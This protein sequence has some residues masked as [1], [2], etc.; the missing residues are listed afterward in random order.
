MKRLLALLGLLLLAA[1]ADAQLF[2]RRAIYVMPAPS[3]STDP[4]LLAAINS[5]ATQNAQLLGY[6][7]G[8][9][10]ASVIQQN[11]PGSGGGSAGGGTTIT[12]LHYWMTPLQIQGS[13]SG[14]GGSSPSAPIIV[15]SAPAAPSGPIIIHSS[16]QPA[17][18]AAPATPA[19]PSPAAPQIT[20]PAPGQP[21]ITIPAPGQPQ[22]TVPAPGQP[23]IVIPAPGQPG[24][25]LPPPTPAVKPG[26]GPTGYRPPVGM[27]RYTAAP[28]LQAQTYVL[29]RLSNGAYAWVPKR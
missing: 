27:Q 18:P 16:P 5:Q 8:Q 14:S 29:V 22:I 21:Q 19:A 24:I 1:P 28:A 12:H 23:Q 10:Q 26:P 2:W 11:A 17:A 3:S 6:L 7:Q 9:Q 20:L 15:P 13:I 25:T 4:A